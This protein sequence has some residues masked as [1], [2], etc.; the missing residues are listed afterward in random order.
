MKVAIIQTDPE[1]E[2][3]K[4]NLEKISVAI[5]ESEPGTMMF[6]LSEMFNTGFTLNAKAVAETMDGYTITWMK[7]KSATTGAAICGSIAVIE[8]GSFLNRLLFIKPDG[9]VAYYDK[10][11]LHSPGGENITYISGNKRVTCN[12]E[13]IRFNLQVCYD[14][15]FPVWSRNRDDADVII[16][17]ASWPEARIYAWKSLLVARAIENQCYVLGANRVGTTPDGTKYCGESLII[18]PLGNIISSLPHYMTGILTCDLN[19]E[20]VDKIRESLP[21]W[22]DADE[23]NI[24]G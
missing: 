19:R 18:D 6:V 10:R 15:R 4:V 11:H 2:N 23:F 16:Y 3:A 13:D 17:S 5:D 24:I 9:S 12:Y 14:L 20:N 1:W 8:K 21:V 22:N 7:E